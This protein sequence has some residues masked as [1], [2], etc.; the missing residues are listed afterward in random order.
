MSYCN[1]ET[2][3]FIRKGFAV[4]VSFELEK[5]K[6]AVILGPSGSGKTTLLRCIAGLEQPASGRIILNGKDITDLPPEK[7]NIGF[8]F[9]DL[10]LFDHLTGRQNIAFGLKLRSIP[11]GEIEKTIDRL[12]RKLQIAHLLDRKPHTMSGGEK[13]RLAFARSLAIQPELLLLDEPLSSLDAPLRKELRG[14]IR[15]KLSAEGL[16]A[17]HV[18][19]DVQEAFELADVIFLMDKGIIRHAGTPAALRE[20]PPDAWTA[21]FLGLGNLIPAVPVGLSDATADFLTALGTVRTLR[22]RQRPQPQTGEPGEHYVLFIPDSAFIIGECC[23]SEAAR[24]GVRLRGTV[25]KNIFE[26]TSMRA[27]VIMETNSPEKMT[28]LELPAGGGI[29]VPGAEIE[30]GIN[31]DRCRVLPEQS[32]D[33]E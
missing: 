1:I 8:V 25:S 12:A 28:K 17:I 26:G 15:E 31:P 30:F 9:Q 32:T 29:F 11:A 33:H 13:Q 10:A 7:R 16:T 20:S 2:L 3:H 5:G 27:E 22:P 18:T 23:S 21:R 14:F 24:H 6:T 19:H 4:H